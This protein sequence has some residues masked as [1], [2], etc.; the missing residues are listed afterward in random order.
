M[1]TLSLKLNIEGLKLN[2]EDSGK[3]PAGLMCLLIKNLILGWG[4][5]NRGLSED[6]RRKFYKISDAFDTAIKENAETID[7]E[8]DW[9]GLIRKAKRDAQLIPNDLLRRVEELI[10]EVKDR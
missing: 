7:L 4:S 1:K 2:D 10:D 9:M 3:S 8:D 5:Q 6:D